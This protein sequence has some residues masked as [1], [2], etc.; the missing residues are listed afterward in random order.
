M[1]IFLI[2]DVQIAKND[3]GEGQEEEVVETE[4]IPTEAVNEEDGPDG[5][6][7]GQVLKMHK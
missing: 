7:P 2:F 3:S 4:E 5:N 1:N 6:L